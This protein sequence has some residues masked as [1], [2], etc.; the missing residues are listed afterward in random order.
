MDDLDQRY[1]AIA[2]SMG[3]GPIVERIEALRALVGEGHLESMNLLAIVLG[4]R[5]EPS[6]RDEI[7]ALYERAHTLGSPVA[8]GNL[9][10][11]YEQWRLS[12]KAD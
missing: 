12:G 9:T 2:D 10:I 3:S 7:V 4:D 11:Q 1:A 6:D 8:A 5:N